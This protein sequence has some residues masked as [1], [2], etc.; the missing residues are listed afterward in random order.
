MRVK[1]GAHCCCYEKSFY[2]KRYKMAS[3]EPSQLSKRLRRLRCLSHIWCHHHHTLSRV[4]TRLIWTFIYWLENC[5]YYVTRVVIYYR[6]GF[7][8]FATK[9]SG[10]GSVGRAVASNSRGP[11][12]KS[13]HRQIFIWNIYCQ[14]YWKDKNKEKE[15]GNGPFK[16]R[17]A[18]IPF[19]WCK[20]LLK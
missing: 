3:A 19:S 5:L 16:K 11:R 9:G 17:F 7:I 13:S 18:T 8:R 2:K 15:A 6:R 14:L 12:S 1:I 10:C 4:W 20:T